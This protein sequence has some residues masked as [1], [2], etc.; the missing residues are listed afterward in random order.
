MPKKVPRSGLYHLAPEEKTTYMLLSDI[1]AITRTAVVE[2]SESIGLSGGMR[3][4]IFELAHNDGIT[5][6][7]L[8][9]ITHLKPPTVSVALGK[10]EKEGLVSRNP[11]KSDLRKTLVH[12]TEKGRACEDR[13]IQV[14]RKYEEIITDSLTSEEAETLKKLLIKAR[15]GVLRESGLTDVRPDK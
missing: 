12:L 4:I 1:C 11:D 10:M 7:E 13:I 8:A 15:A 2:E 14:Y 6:L 9:R 5:Q 3:R